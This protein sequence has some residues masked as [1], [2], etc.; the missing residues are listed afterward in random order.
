M[1]GARMIERKLKIETVPIDSVQPHPD[2]PNQGDVGA[3]VQSIEANGVYRPLV[4]QKDTRHILAGSH[5]WRAIEA[6]GR[7]TVDVTLIDCD[8]TVARRIMIADNR[9][10][11]LA[12]YDDDLLLANL[13]DLVERDA[14]DG[15]GF[16]GDDVD[17]L[18]RR[19]EALPDQGEGGGMPGTKLVV[20][21]DC[22]SEAAQQRLIEH[23][24]G[25]GW[26]SCRAQVV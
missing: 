22:E 19:L 24:M 5:T 8:A 15:S 2:N 21:V 26:T 18:V 7:K 12:T 16:D 17:D 25:E 9:T 3:I 11:Q 23:L 1:E 20:I 6:L 4:V 13:R 10:A 14:L